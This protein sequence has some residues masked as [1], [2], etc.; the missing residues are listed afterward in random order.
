MVTEQVHNVLTEQSSY[1]TAVAI[2]IDSLCINQSDDAIVERTHFVRMMRGIYSSA[3]RVFVYLG[4]P[5]EARLAVAFHL[6][7]SAMIKVRKD[8]RFAYDGWQI[9]MI[10]K[11][12]LQ[13]AT[14]KV[15]QELLSHPWYSRLWAVQEV[16][17]AKRII[18]LFGG[19]WLS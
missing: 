14:L 8:G 4:S 1:W 18:M 10:G 9:L 6:A 11:S 7:P 15:V 17:V 2:W 12:E 19:Y 16:A 3:N 13:Y 5:P